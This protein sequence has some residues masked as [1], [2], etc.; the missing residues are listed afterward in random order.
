MRVSLF[1][2][3]I[4]ATAARASAASAQVPPALGAPGES[5][6]VT[7]PRVELPRTAPSLGQAT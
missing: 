3:A 1:L 7:L 2:L 6:V 5:A 4:V